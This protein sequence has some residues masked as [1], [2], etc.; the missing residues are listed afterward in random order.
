MKFNKK[1]IVLSIFIFFILILGTYSTYIH[2]INNAVPVISN[3]TDNI[4]CCSVV[5]QLDGNNTM[6]SFR[7]DANSSADVFIEKQDW[8]GI[9]SVK[10]YKDEGG[11]FSHVTV[12]HDGWVMGLGGIDNGEDNKRCEQIARKIITEDNSISEDYLKEIQ[13]I[14]KSYK[15]GHI[16][17]KAPNG[18]Y[19]FATPDKVKT[20]H[21][22]P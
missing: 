12:T 4:G 22:N 6:I 17:I 13:L 10:Q 16:L 15:K 11:Y 8:R 3:E 20:G 21:L 7:R 1:I 14:K 19:G 9:P 18:N 2:Q 5:W